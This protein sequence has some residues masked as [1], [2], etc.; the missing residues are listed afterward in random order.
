VCA[1]HR[2]Q[3]GV[4]ACCG[5]VVAVAWTSACLAG[6]VVVN[7]ES[8]GV[9]I[10]P[11]LKS[12]DWIC[13]RLHAGW[14]HCAL[15]IGI[16]TP[17]IVVVVAIVVA[18]EIVVL[19]PIIVLAMVWIEVVARVVGVSIIHVVVVVVVHGCTIGLGCDGLVHCMYPGDLL[20]HFRYGCGLVADA[21]L[22]RCV[23]CAHIVD[24]MF[25]C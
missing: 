6:M 8:M 20:L 16:S 1:R 4:V 3:H 12:F 7:I 18:T 21:V 17:I 22:C 15:L 19:I 13:G 11:V 25:Q 5:V 24:R 9:A 23:R 2:P 14:I 10:V